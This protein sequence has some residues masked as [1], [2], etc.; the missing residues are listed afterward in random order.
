MNKSPQRIDD[1]KAKLLTPTI[2]I[3]GSPLKNLLKTSLPAVVDLASQTI[4]WTVEAIL[5]GQ[6]SAASFAG[7]G[8]AIQVIVV[9]MTI[10][11]TFVVGSSL[12]INRNIG[13]GDAFGANHIFGQ[14]M[15]I[16][17]LI[18]IALAF[19]WYFGATQ[20]FKLIR[21]GG[22][23][24]ESAGVVYLK[25]IAVFAP[26]IVTNFIAIGII[27]G[28]GDTKFSMII[29]LGLNTLNF[30]LAPMLIF[31]W[32][33]LP[34]LEVQGAA[35]AAGI[36]HTAGFLGT[37]Y[38]VRS[39]KTTLFLSFR[40]LTTPNLETFKRLFKAGLPTTVEQLVWSAGQLVVTSYAALLGVTILAAHQV[41]MRIQAILSMFYMGFGMGAM[42]LM[43]KNLGAAQSKLAERTAEI[44]G[45]VMYTV[46]MVVVVILTGFSGLIM[47]VFTSDPEV[48]RVGS[49]VIK[50][51]A[52]VQIPKALNNVLMGNLRGAGDL[53]WL[54]WLG[55]A[56]VF[57]LEIGFNWVAAFVIKWSLL[58]LWL[59]HMFDET[60]RLAANYWRFKR[61]NW[62]FLHV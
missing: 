23:E 24:A 59:V 55:I 54:M 52:L 15:M 31:G 62:K 25:T 13:A 6:I 21:E 41:F 27:R 19:F 34:R 10:L 20:I 57:I 61:G 28:V 2:G 39:N 47:R 9:F 8:M 5:I 50:V 7:V 58:G 33:G 32:F 36:S 53:Q 60:S 29:N 42:T 56:G 51:F 43:G 40:E 49:F 1:G 16:G 17:V 14:A 11:L 45:W 48:I 3:E 44:S 12:I 30:I 4:M 18:S 35:L 46:V 22:Q 37:F 26:F 38:L